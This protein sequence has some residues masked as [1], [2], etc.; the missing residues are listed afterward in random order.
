MFERFSHYLSYGATDQQTVREL[1][2][3]YNGLVV[4]GTVAAFQR[5][6]TGGFV[7]ALSATQAGVR[8]VI[9]P[10]FPLY[11]QPLPQP[12]KSHYALAEV[13]GLPQLVSATQPG[14]SSLGMEEIATIA[15]S[16]VR[17]NTEYVG[18]NRKFEK[19]A[20]RLQEPVEVEGA[21]PPSY[22]LPPYLMANRVDDP[23]WRLSNELFDATRAYAGEVTPCIRVV[24]AGHITGL[25]ELLGAVADERLV[26]WVSDLDEFEAPPDVLA[27]YAAAI[28]IA[29]GRGQLLFALY[30]GFF[31]VL[32]SGFGL[33]GSSHG[34]GYGESRS[35]LELPQSGPPPARYYLPRLHRYVSQELAYQ[36]WLSDRSLADCNCQE[37]R[38]EPPIELEY[39][40]LMRH[41]VLCRAEE[42]QQWAEL[43]PSDMADELDKE[44]YSFIEALE[45]PR[46]P[47]YF[48]RSA[49]RLTD[50]LQRWSGAL[51][52]A[53]GA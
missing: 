43:A 5:Q 19:Y 15:Q 35:W 2:G 37:C 45:N 12:K 20:R 33:T 10:R 4:P 52:R 16:W 34:I 7:L 42:I 41:S 1:A 29:H 47:V 48:K 17:F 28:S 50:H 23:W 18:E 49:E 11:Q 40:A 53:L 8:Y 26:V 31:S 24:A 30:G 46:L 36:L 32:L 51:R 21:R 9:D 13:L 38:G 44:Y 3:S 14:P 25:T 27:D 22:I 6:G 39:H